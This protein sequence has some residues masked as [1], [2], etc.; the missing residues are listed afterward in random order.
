MPNL[1]HGFRSFFNIF[2]VCLTLL[3]AVSASSQANA[4]GQTTE[5]EVRAEAG[6]NGYA[7]EG[8]WLP[9]R[10]ALQN[11]GADINEA[12]LQVSYKDSNSETSVFAAQV[13][14]PTNSR[15]ELTVYV[16]YPQG[17][18]SKLNVELLAD[19]KV[20][21]KTS[22]GLS[23]LNAQS[24]L[25]GLL[26]K[27]PSNYSG[28][29]QIT[30]PNGITK[31]V[32]LH[33][34]D[35]PEKAQGLE[36]LDAILIS[37]VDTG[38]LSSA[39]RAALELWIA[40]GGILLTVGGANWQ[41]TTQGIQGFLPLEISG[42]TQVSGAPE[43]RP[44]S[45]AVGLGSE[46]FDAEADALLAVGKL[47]PEAQI[48]ATQGG[49]ALVVEKALG[50]GKSVFFAADP[51]QKPYKDWNG[52]YNVYRFLLSFKSLP[53]TWANGQWDRHATIEALT[54]IRELAIPSTLIICG[55]LFFYIALIGPVNYFFLRIVKKREW[56]WVTIPA[57]VIAV[58]A[59]S[60]IFGY[61]YRGNTPTL[62][63]LT[64]IQAWDGVQQ[65]QSD[66]LIGLYSPQRAAYTLE[67]KDTA[68]FFPF[69]YYRNNADWFST[70]TSA[71][72][73]VSDIPVEIGGM[74]V[75]GVSDTIAAPE[76]THDLTLVFEDSKALLVGTITNQSKFRLTNV[77][78]VTPANWEALD[79]LG[80]GETKSVKLTLFNSVPFPQFYSET[81]ETLL[82]TTAAQLELDRNMYRKNA[83]LSSILAPEDVAEENNNNWGFYLMG[84]LEG[85]EFPAVL[86][87]KKNKSIDTTFYI[88]QIA[89]AIQYKASEFILT[90]VVFE[91]QSSSEDI[92]PYTSFS[93][94][95]SE[96]SLSFRPA[97]PV[98]FSRVERLHLSLN[99][100]AAPA[101]F[102][103]QLWNYAFNRW[104]T[105]KNIRWGYTNVPRPEEY[106]SS[107]GE[108]T[109]QVKDLNNQ[110]YLD[111]QQSSITLTVSQ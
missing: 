31:L 58:S 22:V 41:A 16:L 17:G 15:K 93:Y 103:V 27:T 71:G 64:V 8:A 56:A 34:K 4:Q 50:R 26:A 55:L 109:L 1:S 70:Q 88:R 81:S 83:F 5:V 91:W 107:M 108:V 43:V 7:K 6:F 76:I 104:D 45:S 80:P 3:I 28:L 18:V 2:V 40:K 96:Y 89:P 47:K 68:L 30:S 54:S 95:A 10:I 77:M 92:S 49:Q 29:G 24:T 66:T 63:Q 99:S 36:T 105:I 98:K 73:E 13:S 86:K 20:I 35:L 42:T 79:E 14:L 53:P 82:Q 67:A 94:S 106:V 97:I 39:Q 44:A 51:G 11:K 33:L 21:A 65:A 52:T 102:E 85:Q 75:I 37:D 61:F 69:N 46:V 90:P 12:S 32:E 84:W 101:A 110:G 57:I 23:I 25:I 60:Y 48:L 19:K 111:M 100:A 59:V 62:N 72:M 78:L 87:D 74:K 38:A 9:V